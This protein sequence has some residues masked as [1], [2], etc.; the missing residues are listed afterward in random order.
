MGD[1]T[2]ALDE[3]RRKYVRM[4]IELDNKQKVCRIAGVSRGALN[5]W[6]RRYGDEVQEE[7]ARET[8]PVHE[9]DLSRI[10]LEKRYEKVLKLLGEKEL[11]VAVLRE[12]IEKKEFL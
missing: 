5:G 4:A 12:M 7:L 1:K 8:I 6:I 3:M 9:G 10:E 2:S 11:E